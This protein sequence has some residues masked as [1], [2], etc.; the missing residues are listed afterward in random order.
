MPSVCLAD[1]EDLTS[2]KIDRFFFLPLFSQVDLFSFSFL[3]TG[4]ILGPSQASQ[5]QIIDSCYHSECKMKYFSEVTFPF[6][7]APTPSLFR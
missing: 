7:P 3:K 6:P 1:W 5:G 4:L 2:L